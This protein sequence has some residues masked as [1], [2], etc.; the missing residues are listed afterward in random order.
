MYKERG[1][2]VNGKKILIIILIII[3][4]VI[5]YFLASFLSNLLNISDVVFKS[6][7]GMTPDIKGNIMLFIV[8][9]FIESL[10][11]LKIYN[12]RVKQKWP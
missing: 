5:N 12:V 11:I 4:L 2:K 6:M 3:G 9:V 7:T 10:I 8:F 1:E